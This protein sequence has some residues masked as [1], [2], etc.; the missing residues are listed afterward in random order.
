[1]G[2]CFAPRLK[3]LEKLGVTLWKEKK[4]LQNGS[5]EEPSNA[6]GKHQLIDD[7]ADEESDEDEMLMKKRVIP[8]DTSDGPELVIPVSYDIIIIS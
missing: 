5:D 6:L 4:D 3:F 8:S 7:D 2:L 1:M